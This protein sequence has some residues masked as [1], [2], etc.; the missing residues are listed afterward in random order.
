[1]GYSQND[2]VTSESAECYEAS[3]DV[4]AFAISADATNV[5]VVRFSNP[6]SSIY[7][8]NRGTG[9]NTTITDAKW[10]LKVYVSK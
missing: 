5:Y 1:M 8:F 7:L 6:A 10:K 9:V 3:H 4:P 2:E